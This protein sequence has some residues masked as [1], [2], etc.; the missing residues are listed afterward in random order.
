M[1]LEMQVVGDVMG[2]RDRYEYRQEMLENGW[3]KLFC[4]VQ[5][6]VVS[7]NYPGSKLDLKVP[8]CGESSQYDL[9]ITSET[10]HRRIKHQKR[11]Q[12]L[13]IQSL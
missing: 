10:A 13:T 7:D 1:M 6:W 11:E 3:Y 2:G 8:I 4:G 5:A 12:I 9:T